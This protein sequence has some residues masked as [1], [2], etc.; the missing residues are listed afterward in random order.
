MI[1]DDNRGRDQGEISALLDSMF[2]GDR[3]PHRTHVKFKLH[4]P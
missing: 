3:L 1:Y 4:R 2:W